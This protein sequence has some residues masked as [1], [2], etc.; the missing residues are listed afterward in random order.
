MNAQRSGLSVWVEAYVTITHSKPEL[1]F[2]FGKALIGGELSSVYVSARCHSIC[3]E[4]DFWEI[5]TEV[6]TPEVGD[7]ILA[8]INTKVSNGKKPYAAFW[9]FESRASDSE[10]LDDYTDLDGDYCPNCGKWLT[11]CNCW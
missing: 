9:R 11:N 3:N 5:T 1:G 2:A 6:V 10:E 8:K 7:E 4:V